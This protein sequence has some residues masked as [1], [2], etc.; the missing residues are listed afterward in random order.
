MGSKRRYTPHEELQNQW[1]R[2]RRRQRKGAGAGAGTD[3]GT[4]ADGDA[5]EGLKLRIISLAK[6][7]GTGVTGGVTRTQY[8][9]FLDSDEWPLCMMV[10]AT[11]TPS[12]THINTHMHIF[13]N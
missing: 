8:K 5:T 11:P 2:Q 9:Q 1:H 13:H 4:G 12:H 7:Q 6:V 3:A 10:C